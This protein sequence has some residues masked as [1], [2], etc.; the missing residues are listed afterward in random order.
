M[1]IGGV[2][3]ALSSFLTSR[4][5]NA[6]MA[7]EARNIVAETNIIPVNDHISFSKQRRRESEES[8]ES[9]GS[10]RSEEESK[11]TLQSHLLAVTS[12]DGRNANIYFIIIFII[13]NYLFIVFIYSYY[14]E[15][16]KTSSSGRLDQHHAPPPLPLLAIIT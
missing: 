1:I 4:R 10:E 13:I 15:F 7:N 3:G 8:E 11:P 14:N 12:S 16:L 2:P 6:N 9:E 5:G